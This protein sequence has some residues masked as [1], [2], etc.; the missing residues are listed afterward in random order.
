M[1]RKVTSIPQAGDSK[2]DAA[3]GLFDSGVGGL[4]VAR[5]IQMELPAERMLYIAD[6]AYAPYGSKSAAE[7]E[8]RSVLL[9]RYLIQCGV[10]ALV[11]ACNTATAAAIN[12]LR[13]LHTIPIIGMEPAVKPAVTLTRTGIVGVLATAGT[14]RSDKFTRLQAEFGRGVEIIT[15]ACPGLV[16]LVEA[17][18]LNGFETRRLVAEYLGRLISRG[19]DTV[20]LGCTHYPFLLPLFQELAGPDIRILDTGFAVTRELRRQLEARNLLA[21]PGKIGG[22]QILSSGNRDVAREI[23]SRLWGSSLKVGTLEDLC[24]A[25]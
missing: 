25:E 2:S 13:E 15:Q 12:R 11:V 16:E 10:K 19:A 24:E 7:V 9:S 17:G 22:L 20:V 6:S 4:T 23:T 18:N 14:L 21:A 8:R 1:T 3:I 5:H